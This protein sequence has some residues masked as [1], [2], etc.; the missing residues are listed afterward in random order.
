[1]YFVFESYFESYFRKACYTALASNWMRARSSYLTTRLSTYLHV[2]TTVSYLI[3]FPW[4]FK[5]N[6][7]FIFF[8]LFCFFVFIHS[9]FSTSLF[10]ILVSV[11]LLFFFLSVRL[12]PRITNSLF[13]SSPLSFLPLNCPFPSAQLLE[14]SKYGRLWRL[15]IGS[16]CLFHASV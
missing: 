7:L 10:C 1:M 12:F 13:F 2:H 4:K 11:R 3:I 15:Y 5:W 16:Q 6:Y 8:F 9:S 14:C